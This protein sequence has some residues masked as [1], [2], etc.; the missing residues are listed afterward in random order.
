MLFHIIYPSERASFNVK[1]FARFN[2]G[3]IRMY[4]NPIPALSAIFHTIKL[5]GWKLP[6]GGDCCYSAFVAGKGYMGRKDIVDRL[7]FSDCQRFAELMN[8]AIYKGGG[9]SPAGKPVPGKA[10][11]PFPVKSLW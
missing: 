3:E 10:K 6:C 5:N 11:V 1:F 8:A 7:Y 4:K 2:K 9:N